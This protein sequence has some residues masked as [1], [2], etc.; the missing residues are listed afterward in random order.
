MGGKRRMAA[1]PSATS[2]AAAARGAPR[3]W[4]IERFPCRLLLVAAF[5]LRFSL[6][7]KDIMAGDSAKI[8]RETR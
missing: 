6:R 4:F 1:A 5:L 7:G 3:S 2:A 8:W